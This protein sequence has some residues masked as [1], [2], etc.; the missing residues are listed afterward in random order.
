MD[1]R[2][3]RMMD[4]DGNLREQIAR[5]EAQA[6]SLAEVVERCTKI[7]AFSRIVI[8]I[9]LA[10][11]LALLFR[12][13]RSDPLAVIAALTATLGGI[14]AYGSNASTARQARAGIAAAEEMRR[15]LIGRINLR[16]VTD[17]PRI[18]H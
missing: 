12:L 6:E 1:G 2:G 8:A 5:L 3:I 7:M 14:V 9:G 13:I 15:Q 11:L 16:V 17:N 10:A 18:L 4:D